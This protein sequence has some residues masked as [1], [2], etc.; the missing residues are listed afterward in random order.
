MTKGRIELVTQ[1]AVQPTMATFEAKVIRCGCGDPDRLH[2]GRFGRPGVDRCP[3]PKPEVEDLGVI[4]YY[5]R[6]PFKRFKWWLLHD[7]IG[8]KR[9]DFGDVK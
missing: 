4:S 7:V 8:L 3:S 5:H 1:D 9:I 2:P 6:N